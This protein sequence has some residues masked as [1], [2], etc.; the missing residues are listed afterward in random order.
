MHFAQLKERLGQMH[1][2][3]KDDVTLAEQLRNRGGK[4]ASR[5]IE[6]IWQDWSGVLDMGIWQQLIV[7]LSAMEVE[8]GQNQPFEIFLIAGMLGLARIVHVDANQGTIPD[9]ARIKSIRPYFDA[10]NERS[11]YVPTQTI[12]D[13]SI[14]FVAEHLQDEMATAAKL[15]QWD[16]LRTLYYQAKAHFSSHTSLK[17]KQQ[18]QISAQN[19]IDFRYGVYTRDFVLA[20]HALDR[21]K[22]LAYNPD[23]VKAMEQILLSAVLQARVE[24]PTTLPAER[25]RLLMKMRLLGVLKGVKRRVHR[26]ITPDPMKGYIHVQDR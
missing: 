7:A 26:L 9:E 5:D 11:R 23:R 22:A 12:H 20:T 15:E 16:K 3:L 4:K 24:S 25:I 19:L 8:R 13:S 1:P 10:L 2:T 6:Q 18:G 17:E 14:D 21:E